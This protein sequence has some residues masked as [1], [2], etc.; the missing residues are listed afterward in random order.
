[1]VIVVCTVVDL[2]V[3][4][5]SLMSTER[6]SYSY[7]VSLLVS[8][9]GVEDMEDSLSSIVTAKTSSNN[10]DVEGAAGNKLMLIY[11]MSIATS[12]L[13]GF[14]LALVF[15]VGSKLLII[16]ISNSSSNESAI[17]LIL[18]VEELTM[19]SISTTRFSIDDSKF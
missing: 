12:S 10:D 5:T 19:S 15:I 14:G 6:S 18:C 4:V 16:A 9:N 11:F 2:G 8:V 1:M 7:V 3:V 17:V 13:L